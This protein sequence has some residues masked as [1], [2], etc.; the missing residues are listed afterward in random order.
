VVLRFADNGSGLSPLALEHVFD[1]YTRVD[2]ME[3]GPGTG[4]GLHLVRRLTEL[5]GGSV[6]ARSEGVGRGSEFTVRL[7]AAAGVERPVSLPAA[8]PRQQEEALRV[9]VVDDHM[10]SAEALAELLTLW[11]YRVRNAVD[12]R[13]ALAIAAEFRPEVVLLDLAMPGMNGYEVAHAMRRMPE[14][15]GTTL[16][17]LTGHARAPVH[18]TGPGYDFDHHW[19]KPLDPAALRAFVAERARHRGPPRAFAT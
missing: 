19:A 14:L 9:L 4:I 12:G 13:E 16:V 2:L 1:L 3:S 17:A 18:A 5:H 11:G 6:E 8:A 15:S 7:P 10:D